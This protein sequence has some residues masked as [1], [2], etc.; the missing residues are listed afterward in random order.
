MRAAEPRAKRSGPRS[1]LPTREWEAHMSLIHSK[2][3]QALRELEVIASDP[4]IALRLIELSRNP[5]AQGEEY[6]RWIQTDPSLTARI[7]GSA[8]SAWH[9][10]GS[11]IDSVTESVRV[12]GVPQVRMIS[13]SHS[14]AALHQSLAMD[15]DGGYKF[16]RSSM[17]KA[18][19]ARKIAECQ[20]NASPEEAYAAGLIQDLGVGLLNTVD[21]VALADIHEKNQHSHHDLVNA[22]LDYFGTDHACAGSVL[23]QQSAIPM[24]ILHAVTCHHHP[25]RT[26]GIGVSVGMPCRVA[27]LLGHLGNPESADALQELEALIPHEFPL[28]IN[29]GEFLEEIEQEVAQLDKELGN[30]GT[31]TPDILKSLMYASQQYARAAYDTVSHNIW[32]QQHKSDLHQQLSITE[33]AHQ[34]AE[35]RAER[36]PL[37]QLFNRSGWDRRARRSL[38]ESPENV[39]LGVAFFD[40]DHFKELNDKH[41][42]AV[43]DAFLKTVSRRMQ[44]AT[45]TSDIVCRWGGDEFVVLFIGGEPGACLDAAYRIQ[46]KMQEDPVTVDGVQLQV[47]ATVGFVSVERRNVDTN[48][49]DLLQL[50]DEQ[51]YK[52]K[53]AQ[54]G[55]LSATVVA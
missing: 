43:G 40:L 25:L 12:M 35:H 41:G 42:H 16:W 2:T 37:T 49:G 9:S 19:A 29:A 34:D 7:L 14:V 3:Q 4:R 21:P 55:T 54:R 31:E 17:R 11:P 24:G 13:L 5:D 18:I 44:A 22:E 47:S 53:G 10:P 48:L 38:K 26:D 32:L 6:A 39:N 8:N 28:W 20:E 1:T 36:D 30:C 27:S 33:R 23:G 51:L 52:A 46:Q 50:A 45:R 15:S